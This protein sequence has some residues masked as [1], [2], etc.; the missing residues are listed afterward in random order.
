MGLGKDMTQVEG[1]CQLRTV[2]T[3]IRRECSCRGVEM[4][5]SVSSVVQEI[6]PGEVRYVSRI[7]IL[8]LQ[9]D[10][11]AYWC[12]RLKASRFWP[13]GLRLRGQCHWDW[14]SLETGM[15][16]VPLS[17]TQNACRSPPLTNR[18]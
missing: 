1:R 7:M 17:F 14:C 2:L 12:Y 15:A 8:V 11:G 4:L 6:L 13:S 10:T 9:V 3:T 18:G 5:A 16:S